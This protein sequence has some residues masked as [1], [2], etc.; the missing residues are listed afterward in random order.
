VKPAGPPHQPG[1]ETMP[2]VA[3]AATAYETGGVNTLLWTNHAPARRGSATDM[4]RDISLCDVS[5]DNS[6]VVARGW[7]GCNGRGMRLNAGVAA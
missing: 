7:S 6:R 3:S 5:D 2:E 4:E 1:N